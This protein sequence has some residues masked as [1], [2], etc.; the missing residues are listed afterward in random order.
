MFDDKYQI[1]FEVQDQSIVDI[2]DENITLKSGVYESGLITVIGKKLAEHIVFDN[3]KQL[4]PLH[5]D[6]I[7]YTAFGD[8]FLVNK[9]T[10]LVSFFEVQYNQLSDIE[11]DIDTFFNDFMLDE[12][13]RSDVL[14]VEYFTSILSRID[15]LALEYDQCLVLKPWL[16]LGG[17]DVESN[18]VVSHF[19]VYFDLVGQ[20]F[21]GNN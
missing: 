14:K 5:Y 19:P 4:T 6:A 8:L 3:W 15:L 10:K 16:L 9:K 21:N 7:A 17:E 20:S 2:Y 18:Y 1:S 13:V 12:D 11:I